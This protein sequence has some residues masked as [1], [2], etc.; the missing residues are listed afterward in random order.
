MKEILRKVNS[1]RYCGKPA[2]RDLNERERKDWGRFS[3]SNGLIKTTPSEWKAN[4]NRV[5]TKK[6]SPVPQLRWVVTSCFMFPAL[7]VKETRLLHVT[8]LSTL[9]PVTFELQSLLKPSSP[10]GLGF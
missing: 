7:L 5:T 1:Q 4:K 2:L 9:P 8:F 10:E 6:G 3:I